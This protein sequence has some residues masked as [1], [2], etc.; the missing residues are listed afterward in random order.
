MKNLLKQGIEEFDD[1]TETDLDQWQ[2]ERG[3]F[4]TGCLE[5][6]MRE[7]ARIHS[8]KPLLSVM[9]GE[10]TV[11]D[12]MFVEQ[13][14][15]LKKPLLVHVDVNT[16][17]ITSLPLNNRTEDECTKAVECIKND[18]STKGGMMKR[19]VFNREPAIVPAENALKG[20]EVE[21]VLKV[22]GQKVGLAEVTIRPIHNKARA[23]KA[24][25]R[26]KYQYLPPNQ[27]NTDLC[28][29]CVQVLNRI[30][31][32]GCDKSPYELFTGN[33]I[34]IVNCYLLLDYE[35]D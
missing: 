1:I 13:G 10:V 5:G 32:K 25:V 3:A 29:D 24:G 16:K 20:M 11:G 6:K 34:D 9:P 8:S 2:E 22:A 31:K 14:A 33:K 26:L 23:S 28:L 4:C 12:I 18:Y 15:S 35:R 7:H 21:L 19:L 30:V 27:F 17:L